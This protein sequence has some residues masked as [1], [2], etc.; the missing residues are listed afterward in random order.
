MKTVA[1]LGSTGSVG[2]SALDVLSRLSSAQS[3]L[4]QYQVVAIGARSSVETLVDQAVA[5][6]PNVIAIADSS[7]AQL[8]ADRLSTH[9]LLDSTEILAG[10]TAMAEAAQTADIVINAVAGF[11]GLP[12][13]VAALKAGKRLGLANKESLIAAGPLVRRLVAASTGEI[14]PVDS[15]HCAIHQCL[16][17]NKGA[18]DTFNSSSTCDAL[19]NG[20]ASDTSSNGGSNN[21][22]SSGDASDTSLAS[23]VLTASGGPFHRYTAEQLA[24]VTVTEALAHPTWKMGPKITIDSSTLMNKG[25]EVI[26][27]HELFGVSYDDIEVVIHP[28][29]IIHSMVTY[30]DGATIA[31]LSMPDMRLCIGYALAFP[32]RLGHQFGTIDWKTVQRFDFEPPNRT[33]FPCLNLAYN[34]GKSGET[35]PAWLNAANEIAVQAFL[36]GQIDWADIARVLST[37]LDV[38]PG[39]E[40]SDLASVIAVDAEARSA[41]KRIVARNAR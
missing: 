11:A 22:G 10:E 39:Y 17:I 5:F 3:Q 18:C 4:A 26:E 23:V 19:S 9:K 6:S 1:V 16:H 12:V 25:L 13:T 30:H 31:Q 33:L 35:A 38:W 15:E 7:K 40:A 21:G 8:L 29:S 32:N 2:T 37:M 36:D 20:R 14:L 28:Q 27:A 24:K 34:A 41:T